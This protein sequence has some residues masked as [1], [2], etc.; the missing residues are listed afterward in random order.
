TM[1][2]NAYR[3]RYS[4]K[5]RV[6]QHL[7]AMREIVFKETKLRKSRLGTSFFMSFLSHS[8]LRKLLV[9]ALFYSRKVKNTME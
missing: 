6:I 9:Q 2:Q 3:P 1:D 5:G 8:S 4:E 7:A